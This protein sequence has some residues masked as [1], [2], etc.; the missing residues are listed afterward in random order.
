MSIRIGIC[1]FL[2]T[3]A[4]LILRLWQATSEDS[5]NRDVVLVLVL[6]LSVLLILSYSYSCFD[7]VMVLARRPLQP[8][9]WREAVLPAF[10]AWACH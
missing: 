1:V 7:L 4:T 2:V 10:R 9:V 8:W 6:D 5:I 3:V